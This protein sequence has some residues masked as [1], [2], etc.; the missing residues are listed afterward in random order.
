VALDGLSPG[1]EYCSRLFVTNATGAS[2]DNA[3]NRWTA[4][5]PELRLVGASP[6]SATTARVRASVNPAGSATNVSFKYAAAGSSPCSRHDWPGSSA[7]AAE[8]V[9]GDNASHEI[10]TQIEGLA[11]ATTYCV[12]AVATNGHQALESGETTFTT[13]PAD[14]SPPPPE[15][16][17]LRSFA[18]PSRV[19]SPRFTGVGATVELGQPG[20]TLTMSAFRVVNGSTGA[21]VG[22]VHRELGSAGRH[23]LTVLL[24][25]SARRGLAKLSS[26]RLRVTLIAQGVDGRQAKRTADVR[27]VRRG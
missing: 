7:T 4:G 12:W 9:P 17:L 24:T 26:V 5:A 19:V 22:R 21:R 11:P 25:K 27:L 6:L 2:E 1:T 20:A 16:P 3:Y 8:T 18:L 10:I 23:R 15:R 13:M 14:A